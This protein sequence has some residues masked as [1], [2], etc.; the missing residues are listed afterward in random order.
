MTKTPAVYLWNEDY[1]CEGDIVHALCDT[2]PYVAWVDAGHPPGTDDADVELDTLARRFR[3]N[4]N[5]ASSVRR[6]NFPV[7]LDGPPDDPHAVCAA[8][9]RF[10]TVPE[11]SAGQPAV[12]TP[13]QKAGAPLPPHPERLA[14]TTNVETSIT[15]H[16]KALLE[17]E[18]PEERT[19]AT[20]Y[21]ELTHLADRHHNDTV[22]LP[23][24]EHLAACILQLLN[25]PVGRIDQGSMDKQ[26]RDEVRR[27]GGDEQ[28]L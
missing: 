8:C 6:H 25:G 14:M 11:E 5:S 2:E 21:T 1:W 19:F 4:R 23:A 26:V 12:M 15:R 27:A 16:A 18:T 24:V 3:V 28:D 7:K 10:F 9:L 20:L 17:P 13:N 22:M